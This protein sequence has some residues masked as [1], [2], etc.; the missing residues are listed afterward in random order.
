MNR[1]TELPSRI[2]SYLTLGPIRYRYWMEF[3][4]IEVTALAYFHQD[5]WQAARAAMQE[6]IDNPP[7]DEQ[8]GR[9]GF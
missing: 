6:Y 4:P 7:T 9:M 2:Q 3:A 1:K 8:L 5:F